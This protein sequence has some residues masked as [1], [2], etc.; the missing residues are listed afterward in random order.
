[1][2]RA[3]AKSWRE[4]LP[5]DVRF[6]IAQS[7][8]YTSELSALEREAVKDARKKRLEEFS[9][10]RHLLKK[11][12]SSMRVSYSDLTVNSN[13][14]VKAPSGI[15][16]TI[17]HSG[18]L[19]FAAAAQ[20]SSFKS[21]GADM[22]LLNDI[23]AEDLKNFLPHR[24]YCQIVSD[25][26]KQRAGISFSL[27]ESVGKCFGNIEDRFMN[28]DE[29]ILDYRNNGAVKI[30]PNSNYMQK[31]FLRDSGVC[32]YYDYMVSNGFILTFFCINFH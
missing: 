7:S 28:F 32:F 3:L 12:L 5:S 6:E 15:T 9:A 29:I 17:S 2:L 31:N 11:I 21:I 4:I 24:E 25:R 27:R 10:G 20:K 26:S 8:D 16:C 13:G 1:M 22:E 19:V 18:G 23:D 14:S 30:L